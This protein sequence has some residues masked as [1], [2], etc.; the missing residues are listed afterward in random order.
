MKRLISIPGI[1]PNSYEI[2]N[3][4]TPLIDAMYSKNNEIAKLLI[5]LDN[6][7]INRRNFQQKT[8]LSIAANLKKLKSLN[9]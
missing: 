3:G 9:Y 4:N 2:N 6:T 1:D 5:E 8:A 7:D